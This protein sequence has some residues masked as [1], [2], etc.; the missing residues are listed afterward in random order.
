MGI[1]PIAT[2]SIVDEEFFVIST[3]YDNQGSLKFYL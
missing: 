2:H 1:V 3:F